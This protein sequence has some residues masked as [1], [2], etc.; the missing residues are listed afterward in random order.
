MVLATLSWAGN[1]IAG[2]MA[3]GTVSPATLTFFRWLLALIFVLAFAWRHVLR[4]RAVII[5]HWRR[6]FVMG[7]AG[8]TG[9]CLALYGALEYTTALNAAI[10]QSCM[11]VAIMLGGYLVFRQPFGKIQAFGVMLSVL[12]V[13]VTVT[14]GHPQPAS[15]QRAQSRRRNHDA[16]G[17]F[18]FGVY[19]AATP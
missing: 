19:I 10:E 11:P 1:T 3:A 2:R 16:G 6:L 17:R 8:F 15:R 4:D 7:L 5:A 18:L 12:G 13:L 14:S 9:F